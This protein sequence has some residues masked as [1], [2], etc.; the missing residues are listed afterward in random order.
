MSEV[1]IEPYVNHPNNHQQRTN[2]SMNME[3]ALNDERD[4]VL[5]YAIIIIFTILVF[6]QLVFFSYYIFKNCCENTP[7]KRMKR[8]N[9]GMQVVLGKLEHRLD[10]EEQETLERL[11]N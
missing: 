11:E 3:A 2:Y 7:Y 1:Y 6:V 9:N 8:K 4:K 10:K 5:F